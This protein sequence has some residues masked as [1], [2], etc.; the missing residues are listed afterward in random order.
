MDAKLKKDLKTL[1]EFIATFCYRHHPDANKAP[2]AV[3]SP[4]S[5][6]ILLNNMSLCS[7]CLELLEHASAKR[8][9]CTMQPKPTCRHCPNHC[10]HPTYR[11]QIRQVMRSSGMRMLLGGRIHYLWRLLF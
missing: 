6:R 9:R 11:Q 4:D 10:Y 8:Y 3:R 5:S 1:S 2:V 7:D